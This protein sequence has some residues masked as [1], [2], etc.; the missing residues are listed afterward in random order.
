MIENVGRMDLT[1]RKEKS[2]VDCWNE[3]MLKR[4]FFFRILDDS[5]VDKRTTRSGKD[6]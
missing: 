3:S 2:D 6:K 4:S 5:M 1:R